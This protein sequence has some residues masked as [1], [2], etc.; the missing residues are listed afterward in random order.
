MK[1]ILITGGAGFIGA[2]L[3]E[4]LIKKGGYKVYVL[5]IKDDPVNLRDVI[6]EVTYIHGDI[7]DTELVNNIFRDVE[8]DGV[9]HLAAVS[10]V[11][12]GEKDPD[13][14]VSTN[15]GGTKTV[16]EALSKSPAKPW[17]IYGSSREVYGEPE[18]L[19]VRESDPKK[20]INIYGRA[21]LEGEKLT[22]KYV[23]EYGIDAIILRFSNVY[24]NEKDIMDRV[25]PRFVL[26]AL[27]GI[28]LEIHGGAQ[29]FDFTFID[30]TVRGIIASM[31]YLQK[32]KGES[33]I[34]DFHLL[35]GKATKIVELP[36]I[37]S[38]HLG[39]NVEVI[40]T[41]P[42]NYDVEHF[43]GDP[44]K[45]EEMLGFKAVMDI[46]EGI[47]LTIKRLSKLVD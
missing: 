5:D 19:P 29:V 26:N 11:I 44:S 43:Y 7:R 20:P 47:K 14:C 45:A 8:F 2:T 34:E 33:V 21:K 17:F 42:R 46:D 18:K 1:K 38:R 13:L 39:K 15:V 24:G 35:T 22:E 10:R 23:K 25:I 12:W 31:E 30:D 41:E 3:A 9:V 16:L 4:E 27:K 36:E 37:I 28:P 40:Y 32:H 6:D